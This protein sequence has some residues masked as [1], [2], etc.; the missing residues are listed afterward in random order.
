[1]FELHACCDHVNLCAFNPLPHELFRLVGYLIHFVS[2]DNTLLFRIKKGKN[3]H[4]GD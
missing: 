1:M 2:L 4:V 3:V